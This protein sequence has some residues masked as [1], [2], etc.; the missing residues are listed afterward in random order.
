MLLIEVQKNHM[1][2]KPAQTEHRFGV[3]RKFKTIL[4]AA[5]GRSGPQQ[6]L[7]LPS[8]ACLTSLAGTSRIWTGLRG[9]QHASQNITYTLF[10]L[11]EGWFVRTVVLQH[12][13][14]QHP[15]QAELGRWVSP[16][17]KSVMMMTN[18]CNTL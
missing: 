18:A 2:D 11:R 4:A 8:A 3:N 5:L 10:M 17:N 1:P 15:L 13:D 9:L 6:Q 12:L 16:S 14:Q 7:L